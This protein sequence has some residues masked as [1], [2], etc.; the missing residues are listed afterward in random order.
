MTLVPKLSLIVLGGTA[1]SVGA[2]TTI[3]FATR[4]TLISELL[5]SDKTKVALGGSD[6]WSPTWKLYVA[7]SKNKWNLEGE[8]KEGEVHAKF[9]ETCKLKISDRVSGK[10]SQEYKDF[11][12]WCTKTKGPQG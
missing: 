11:I 3:Y 7:N 8:L 2:G 10:D 5:K 6:D 12:N 4:G 1:L 9:K